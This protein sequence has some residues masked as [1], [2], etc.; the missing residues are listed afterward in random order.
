ML[1][2]GVQY[3]LLPVDGGVSF[4]KSVAAFAAHQDRMDLLEWLQVPFLVLLVPATY[5]VVWAARR[6]APRLT[7][8]GALVALTGLLAGFGILGGTPRLENVTVSEGLDVATMAR[9]ATAIEEHPTTLLGG[10][11]FILGITIGLLLLG[12][13][14]W[15]SRVAP[16]WMGIALAA[17]GFTH[18]FMPGHVAAG[19][20]LI[21][22]AV[23]FAGASVALLRTRNDDFDLP[24]VVPARPS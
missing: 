11:L 12:I 5:A 6:A 21:V 13:A 9:V 19:I 23:G 22:A 1:F 8:A 18:P 20:G 3:V 15:R 17:G 4:E 24:P 16:A 14:L 7:T 2:M 10:L